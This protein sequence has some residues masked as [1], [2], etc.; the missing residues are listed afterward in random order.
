MRDQYSC[1][2]QE[3]AYLHCRYPLQTACLCQLPGQ[4]E[5]LP[6]VRWVGVVDAA[7]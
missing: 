3:T 2:E 6:H 1:V 7:H 5:L 4:R